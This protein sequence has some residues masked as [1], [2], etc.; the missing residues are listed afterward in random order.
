MSLPNV[1]PA[2]RGEM[3]LRKHE[4]QATL[5]RSRIINDACVCGTCQ[6]ARS[7]GSDHSRSHMGPS[8]GTSWMRSSA[9]TWSSESML[10]DRPPCRQKICRRQSGP[11][12]RRANLVLHKRREGQEVEQLGEVLPHAGGAIL[13]QALV[14][15]AVHLRDLPALVVATQDRHPLAEPH[16]P[17]VTRAA[18]PRARAF[19]ATSNVTVSTL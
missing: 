3:P 2:P 1:Y 4:C 14:V 7:S 19:S 17:P 12:R 11:P 16:L 10:G 9:R 6:P 15:E 8:C 13:A 5:L 18:R